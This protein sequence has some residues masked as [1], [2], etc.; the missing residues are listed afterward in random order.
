M[1]KTSLS[2]VCIQRARER[3]GG[4]LST[5]PTMVYPQAAYLLREYFEATNWSL[6]NHYHVLTLPSRNLLDFPV[7]PGLNV[8]LS[9]R[10]T[11]NF[12]SHLNL[13]TLVPTQTST[14]PATPAPVLSPTG[15]QLLAGQLTYVYSSAPLGFTSTKKSATGQDRIRFQDVVQSF[16][17][18]DLPTRPELRDDSR[19]TWRGGKRVDKSGESCLFNRIDQTVQVCCV[20]TDWH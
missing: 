3:S 9:H 16:K 12:V 18:G 20:S 7:P 4:F 17:V 1:N 19:E 2:R 13:S 15:S 8:A 11:T 10:P 5:A 6:D 14:Y